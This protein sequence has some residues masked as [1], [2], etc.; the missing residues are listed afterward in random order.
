MRRQGRPIG[1]HTRTH[2]RKPIIRTQTV[3]CFELLLADQRAAAT[4]LP[5][6]QPAKWAFAIIH[7]DC[8]A[9]L[10][11]LAQIAR[12]SALS[13]DRCDRAD[14]LQDTTPLN[15]GLWR[16]RARARPRVGSPFAVLRDGAA[17]RNALRATR[18][19]PPVLASQCKTP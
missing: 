18:G 9:G 16:R 17:G 4:V 7:E 1:R 11:D 13:L 15:G 5:V 14:R 19:L 3:A 2:L 12:R 8:P 10:V 6:A